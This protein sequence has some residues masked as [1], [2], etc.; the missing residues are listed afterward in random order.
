MK[1]AYLH[2][3]LKTG[4]VTTVIRQQVEALKDFHD[5]LVLTG[6]MPEAVW[7]ADVVHIPQLAYTPVFGHRIDPEETADL[8]TRALNAKWPGQ[9]CDLLHIHNPF[10]AKNVFFLQIIKALKKM[11]IRLFLQLHDFAEDGRPQAYFQESYPFDCHFGVINSRDYT[12]LRQAGLKPDGLHQINNTVNPLLFS[13]KPVRRENRVLYP[14]RAIRRKNIGEAILLSL[15]F[16]HRETLTITLP[17]NSSQDIK[18][19]EDWKSWT[20]HQDLNI[21]FDAGLHHDFEGLVRAS[22]SI[23][24]TSITEGFGFSFLE[25]WTAEKLLWGRKLPDICRDFES[26]HIDLGHLYTQLKIPLN[27]IGKT[28][29]AKEWQ[30]N[31]RRISGQFSITV[32]EPMIHHTFHEVIRDDAIDFGLLHENHQKSIIAMLLKSKTKQNDLKDLNPF[33]QSPGSVDNA[34][35]LI[36][37]NKIAVLR[38]YHPKS[39]RGM[40]EDVYRRVMQTTVRHAI[41]KKKLLFLFLSPRNLSHLKWR[42]YRD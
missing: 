26:N 34:E 30:T 6:E 20:R 25:P 24:T 42:P 8:I 39:Y 32:S 4:G 29:L 28:R 9:G 14:I 1:I 10:L 15:Y 19:Y 3:H 40:L 23:M 22:R 5:L 17:P 7:P 36:K 12:I 37:N 38:H 2:Y 13:H 31:M 18:S 21:E 27:W 33:L 41:D 16:L 11:E 35:T